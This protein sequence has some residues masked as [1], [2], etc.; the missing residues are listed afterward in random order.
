MAFNIKD[1]IG[2]TQAGFAREA[3]FE[4]IITLPK[5]I[6]GDSRKLSFFCSSAALPDRRMETAKVR[7]TGQGFINSFVTGSE[8]GHLDVT[9]YCDS[10]ADNL[11]LIHR[12]M[13]AMFE[14]QGPSNLHCVAYR[15]DYIAKIN[16]IQYDTQGNPIAEFDF[17]EAFPEFISKV[18]FSWASKD[19]IITVPAS[20]VYS[21]YIEKDEGPNA[22]QKASTILQAAQ[23]NK[24]AAKA[25]QVINTNNSLS[26]NNISVQIAKATHLF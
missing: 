18:N 5:I 1:F 14:V 8:Y 3:H 11:K 21:Y 16:L 19:A 17:I 26:D 9:F 10:K 15:D 23:T 4:L 24:L 2:Q 6:S 12:W 7:R 20:F 25:S 22:A 13:N